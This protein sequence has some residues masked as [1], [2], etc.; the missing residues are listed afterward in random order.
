MPTLR[1][2]KK[3]NISPITDENMVK[4]PK[5]PNSVLKVAV[6]ELGYKALLIG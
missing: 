3:S 1:I 4:L 2:F 6:R 5:Y